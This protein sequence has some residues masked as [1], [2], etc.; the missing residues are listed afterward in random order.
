VDGA[1]RSSML[2]GF[3]ICDILKRWVK[4]VCFWNGG[5]RRRSNDD[6]VDGVWRSSMLVDIRR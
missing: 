5:G 6:D 3:V 2:G 4:M 1:L